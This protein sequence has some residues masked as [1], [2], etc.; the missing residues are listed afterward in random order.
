MDKAAREVI[1][2]L[3]ERVAELE[4]QVQGL[5]NSEPG[6]SEE[7]VEDI[8]QEIFALLT[9]YL[10][11]LGIGFSVDDFREFVLSVKDKVHDGLE[12][13]FPGSVEKTMIEWERMVTRHIMSTMIPSQKREQTE[14]PSLLDQEPRGI[15]GD[16]D[17]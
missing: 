8:P 7:R 5:M 13:Q 16:D 11:R 4:R 17:E 15:S 3:E 1:I 14:N 12:A 2:R 9:V 6:W 10:T